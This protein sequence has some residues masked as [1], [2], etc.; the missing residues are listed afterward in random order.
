MYRTVLLALLL[1]TPAFG[2]VHLS[3][4]ETNP[5]PAQWRGFLLDLRA[6]RTA[7]NPNAGGFRTATPLRDTYLNAALKLEAKAKLAALSADDAADLGALYLRLGQP[8]KAVAVLRPAR[9]SYPDHFR[10]AA[11]LGTAWQLS[12]NLDQAATDLEDAVRFAPEKWKEAEGLHL[13]LVRLRA[14]EKKGADSLDDLFGPKPP[15]NA[16]ALTQQLCLWLPNDPRLLW[17]LAE[18]A[19]AAGDVRTAANLLDGCVTEYGLKS[20]DARE[21][22]K[23]YRTAA[24]E[25]DKAAD[26]KP[27]DGIKFAS[28]RVFPKRFDLSRLPKIDPNRPNPLP[29]AVLDETEIGKKFVVKYL[30]YVNDLDGLPVSVSGFMQPAKADE[31]TEFLLT[32]F[33]VGCWFCE[34]PGPLQIVQ[35][36]AADG[37]PIAFTRGMVTVTGKLHL[38]RTD[39][40]RLLFTVTDAKVKLAE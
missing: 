28:A 30:P 17:Q 13:K 19:H 35:V 8:E 21:R 10:L 1:A 18:L 24:D 6:V 5:L 29:W 16:V 14:K 34:S 33:P 26:H 39:P 9:R 38:N 7:G 2:G 32:E 4:D 22:R 40:E 23:R 3:T 25:L 31:V 20:E 27:F 36:D 37:K 12:G 15:A 11:N